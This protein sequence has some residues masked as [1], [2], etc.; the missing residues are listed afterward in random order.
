MATGSLQ[1]RVDHLAG[2]R[3]RRLEAIVT[4]VDSDHPHAYP[5]EH[6]TREVPDGPQSNDRGPLPRI[7]IALARQR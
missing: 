6:L 5:G 4:D 3:L 1:G 2:E 7:E